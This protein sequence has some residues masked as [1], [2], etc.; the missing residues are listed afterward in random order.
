MVQRLSDSQHPPDST[1]T[2]DDGDEET[3]K[4]ITAA[5]KPLSQDPQCRDPISK[6]EQEQYPVKDLEAGKQQEQRRGIDP[7]S[8][9]DEE[10]VEEQST[11]TTT[12]YTHISIPLP[13]HDEHG[14][15]ALNHDV[16]CSPPAVQ[17]SAKKT[18]F[19]LFGRRNNEKDPAKDLET[20]VKELE[21]EL[22]KTIEKRSVP[23]F[24]AVCLMEYT[25][26]ERICWSSNPECSHVFH[27]D[28]I[29]QWLISLGKT[30]TKMQRFAVNPTEEE[31]LNY[32][33]ECPCCRQ[34]FILKSS[35][36]DGCCGDDAV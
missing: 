5:P 25:V 23:I 16:E 18:K 19:R 17:G 9:E 36:P 27:E 15:D 11:T 14:R 6:E 34:D 7:P 24:C 2:N 29:V 22:E 20:K 3:A 21:N 12:K 33:L 35:S 32:Q 26:S 13:G 8:G 28:C 1:N 4:P 10:K 31:L 30:K